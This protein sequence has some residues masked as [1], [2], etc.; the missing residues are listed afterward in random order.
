MSELVSQD[1]VAPSR[2]VTAALMAGAAATIIAWAAQ[3]FGLDVPPG[4]E[5]A[6]A[7][8]LAGAAG[9]LRKER[10]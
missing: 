7:T 5:A 6:F 9:Y 2:K 10:A 3:Q 4:I 1:T 8:L